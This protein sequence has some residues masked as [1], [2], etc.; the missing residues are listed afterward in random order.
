MLAA[1]TVP[2]RPVAVQTPTRSSSAELAAAIASDARKSEHESNSRI[3]DDLATAARRD[4]DL[5]IAEAPQ[6][7]ACVYGRGVA[8]GLEA[9]A[10]PAHAIA[11]L[12]DMLATLE[13]AEAIDPT[14]DYAGPARVQALV[15]IRAPGWPLGPGDSERGLAAAERAA[16]LRPEY[17]PNWLAVAEAHVKSGAT[18][19]ARASYARARE[20]ASRQ[21]DTP[22]RADWLNEAALGLSRLQ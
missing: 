3:R 7:V 2:T 5:C 18:V 10:H 22:D 8:L 6:A 9:R 21:P 14:Y 20:V 11:I 19:D 1:C 16:A 15:W 13:R 12:N 17:P 4:A